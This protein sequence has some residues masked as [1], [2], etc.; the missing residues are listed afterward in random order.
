MVLLQ[1]SFLIMNHLY[2]LSLSIS[3]IKGL[4]VIV[5]CSL[6]V[7]LILLALIG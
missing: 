7:Y 3:M 1:E 5:V 2:M 6:L 4:V